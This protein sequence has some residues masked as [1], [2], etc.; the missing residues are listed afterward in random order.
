MPPRPTYPSTPATRLT[1]PRPTPT[2]PPG[3]SPRKVLLLGLD[4]LR[5][6]HVPRAPHLQDLAREGM[7]AVSPL[8]CSPAGVTGSGSGWATV[9]SG[10]WPDRNNVRDGN[11]VS[12][13]SARFPDLLTRLKQHDPRHSTAALTCWTAF[14]QEEW[15]GGPIL[16][17]ALDLRI[18]YDCDTDDPDAADAELT[19]LAAEILSA[20]SP[21]LLFVHF[22]SL[23]LAGHAGGAS[24]PRYAHSLAAVDRAV[25]RLLDTV[26]ARPTYDDEDWLI[27]VTN[28]HGHQDIGEVHNG[29]SPAERGWCLIAHGT[30]ITPGSSRPDVRTVDVA[31]TA[32]HHLGVPLD[33][34][35]GLDGRPVQLPLPTDPF[36]T[37]LPALSPAYDPLL[38]PLGTCGGTTSTPPPG[39][40]TDPESG[41]RFTTDP[42]WT[43]QARARGRE[44][45]VRARGVFAVADAAL[46]H[47]QGDGAHGAPF[48]ATLHSAPYDTTQLISLTVEF[49]AHYRQHADGHATV[50]ATFDDGPEQPLLRFGPSHD[51]ANHG[52]E[53]VARP[54][55][56]HVDVPAGAREMRLHW[57]LTTTGS[58]WFAVDGVHVTS[59]RLP[60]LTLTTDTAMPEPGTDI[61]VTAHGN[62]P[63]GTTWHLFSDL[64]WKSVPLGPGR[65]RVEVPSDAPRTPSWLTAE[66]RW[67]GGGTYAETVVAVP[68][69]DLN[70][71]KQWTATGESGNADGGGRTWPSEILAGTTPG[72][73]GDAVLCGGQAIRLTGTGS[74]LTLLAGSAFYPGGGPG[75]VLLADG[76]RHPFD[77]YI[78]AW[79]TDAPDSPHPVAASSPD[80]TLHLYRL[81]VPLPPKAQVTGLLLPDCSDRPATYAPSP[82]VFD[83][84]LEAP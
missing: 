53:T 13:R 41:W 28:D 21:D 49:M 78:P 3:I 46:R 77:L 4:G 34:A 74:A 84:R 37:L 60:A 18:G 83:V 81:T 56:L 55:R 23:D 36:D 71:A 76:T 24:L 32:L 57:R 43:A 67:P 59:G 25:G 64:D 79:D 72:T 5:P 38:I 50:T 22:G 54:F 20:H 51:T 45:F 35:W 29:P 15:Y 48:D 44:T 47:G 31:P 6:D 27:L 65:W 33:P 52:T 80:G 30:G 69:P 75:A 73:E 42:H 7:F 39:W 26:R 40:S 11:L 19:E 62:V 58:G 68:H 17:G 12:R 8:Y 70:A 16:S 82:Y 9:L 14:H 63:P 1:D 10:V 61:L 2:P 66:A